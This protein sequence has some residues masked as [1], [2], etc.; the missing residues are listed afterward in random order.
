[1]EGSELDIAIDELETRVERLRALYEQFFMGIEKIPPLVVQKDVDRRL[2]QLR[3]AQIRNTARRFKLQNIIQRYNTFQQYWMRILRE[4]ENGTYRR[5]VL[6]AERTM[7]NA[8][9]LTAAERKRQGLPD[10][11]TGIET[12]S[13]SG[14]PPENEPESRD[15][16]AM[17]ESTDAPPTTRS[18]SSLAPPAPLSPAAVR[19][20]IERDLGLLL[21]D[22]LDELESLQT[23]ALGRELDDPLLSSLPPAP[24]KKKASLRATG[25]R[26]APPSSDRTSSRSKTQHPSV[27]QPTPRGLGPIAPKSDKTSRTGNVPPS[28]RRDSIIPHPV[29]AIEAPLKTADGLGPPKVSHNVPVAPNPASPPGSRV[30]PAVAP[31][32]LRLP[33]QSAVAGRGLPPPPKT[34]GQIG[35]AGPQ[36]LRV[37]R[38]PPA[39]VVAKTAETPESSE[40]K[41]SPRGLPSV[42]ESI[43]PRSTRPNT[44][45]RA[46]P[47]PQTPA[48]PRAVVGNAMLAAQSGVSRELVERVGEKLGAARKQTHENVAVSHEALA[49]KLSATLDD[50][51]RRH[52]GKKVDFDVV[53]KDG[54]AI[55]KPIVR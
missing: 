18:T 49:K 39:Q 45:P 15:S 25:R 20:Q 29:V 28:E 7:G 22:E 52:P 48:S 19:S 53:I 44:P 55:V 54:K 35:T 2:Y 11:E 23:F 47:Q 9:L 34:A 13:K 32:G 16:D 26:T 5:H 14:T 6:R 1:M 51:Q 24:R 21:D 10:A 8:G 46:V 4:I 12:A 3:R 36:N 42:R 40:P 31:K 17:S 30:A 27:S 50:L 33:A 41:P 43:V 37:E 38:P